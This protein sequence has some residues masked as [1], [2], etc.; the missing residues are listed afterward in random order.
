MLV[1]SAYIE[2][3]NF[4]NLNCRDCYNSSGIQKNKQEIPLEQLIILWKRLIAM[5]AHSIALAGGEPTL[6]SQWREILQEMRKDEYA[7]S[8]S[9]ATNGTT[10]NQDLINL[11]REKT[12]I[13]IQISLDGSCEEINA[14]NRGKGSFEKA[15]YTLKA[16]QGSK[17]QPI[18]KMVI[19]RMNLYDIASFYKIA[20]VYGARPDFAFVNKCGNAQE[21][22]DAINVSSKEKAIAMREI[23]RL[24]K[25]TGVEAVV[26][27]CSVGCP[28]TEEDTKLGLLIKT[29]GS[30][31]P[32]QSLYND[33]YS[34]GNIFL[35][36]N[37]QMSKAYQKISEMAKQRLEMEYGCRKCI[38]A[39][40]CQKGC[41]AMAVDMTDDFFACDGDCD[42][43][44]MQF[45]AFEL[46]E[47]IDEIQN[48]AL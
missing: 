7:C 8:F 9:I 46:K 29:N 25:E 14:A 43:R 41:P 42:A 35:D 24:G 27:R 19:T 17:K 37:A 31:Q 32:C 45:V 33:K 30:V 47:H 34:L 3:N 6:H 36:T 38:I 16:L 28:F 5:G 22:F 1:E 48:K 11:C 18:L 26:P 20:I 44:R 4:C 39:K 2:I 12:N 23:A 10:Y 40:L 21:D 13:Y 15:L